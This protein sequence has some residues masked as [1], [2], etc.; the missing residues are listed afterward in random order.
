VVV[1]VP[2]Y[3]TSEK[4]VPA[5]TGA[6]A[7]ADAV[8]AVNDGSTDD[9]AQHLAASGCLTVTLPA[10]A[11]K[12]AALAA[13]FRAVLEGPGGLL[14]FLPDYVVTMDG[15][16]QHD[17][18]DIPRLVSCA[19]R[20]RA[21]LVLGMR[22][23]NAMPR[24]NRIGAH[25]SRL[26]FLIGASTHVPD[27]QSG[28]RLL[29]MPLVAALIDR[30]TWQGYESESEVLWR[31]LALDRPMAA[32][33]I[34]TIYLDGNRGSQFDAWRDSCRIAA[35]FTESLR[36]TVGMAALDF[37]AFAVIFSAGWL[38]PVAANVAA[39]ALAV[40][41]QA[42]FRRDY[43]SRTRS[44]MRK[45]GTGAVLV[46]FAGHLALTTVLLA[47]LVRLGAPPVPG[48]ALAQLTGYLVTFVAVD[49]ALLRRAARDCTAIN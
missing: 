12:G 32:A 41:C 17:P 38:A 30:V 27:T 46:T 9:T 49:A 26:L 19:V 10:N 2:C 20:A 39:R 42:A 23:P 15:D 13:G 33:P 14:G 29:A 31:T 35:V 37:A 11:G 47:G 40:A 36:W 6:T 5:I 44:L 43:A 1:I 48:K 18:R 3:N 24:K 16:G 34:S 4:C 28:F 21:D 25:Y 7:V 8:L 22:D 45:E